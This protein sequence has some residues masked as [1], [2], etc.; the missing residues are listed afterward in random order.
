M[1]SGYSQVKELEN[2]NLIIEY[3]SVDKVSNTFHLNSSSKLKSDKYQKIKVKGKLKILNKE[4]IDIN[5]IS[6]IDHKNKLRYRPTDI[7]YQ[8]VLGYMVYQ[9]ILKEDIKRWNEG[10]KNQMGFAFSPE[11]NDGFLDYNLESYTNIEL[12]INFGTKNK[13]ILRYIYFGTHKFKS[14]KILF[15][16]P[17]IKDCENGVFELYYGDEKISSVEL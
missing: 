2:G 13:P 8:P 6:L 17:I 1:V 14:F 12:P 9:K 16:F 3:I 10:F 7:S 15:F 5:K 4:K 11:V